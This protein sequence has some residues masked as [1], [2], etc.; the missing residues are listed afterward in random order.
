MS[1]N[2]RIVLAI[3]GSV[4]L[5]TVIV[6]VVLVRRSKPT[7]QALPAPSAPVTQSTFVFKSPVNSSKLL[8]VR[9]SRGAGSSSLT[10]ESPVAVFIYSD[11]CDCDAAKQAFQTFAAS[12]ASYFVFFELNVSVATVA[13]R[14]NELGLEPKTLPA[15]GVFRLGIAS[16]TL[17]TDITE[18]TLQK[19]V[20]K[21]NYKAPAVQQLTMQDFTATGALVNAPQKGLVVVV[22]GQCPM[23]D[24]VSVVIQAFADRVPQCRVYVVDADGAVGKEFL[25]ASNTTV[26][27]YPS[28]L[29]YSENVYVKTPPSAPVL[30]VSGLKA[31]VGLAS[32]DVLFSPPV[33]GAVTADRWNV[34][35]G[36]FASFDPAKPTLIFV[37]DDATL[38]GAVDAFQ[39]FARKYASLATYE[40]L[41]VSKP[42]EFVF[43]AAA[44]FTD[45]APYPVVVKF[46]VGGL[47]SRQTTR[48]FSETALAKMLAYDFTGSVKSVPADF[49]IAGTNTAST[50][51]TSAGPAVVFV[52]SDAC[53]CDAK[54]RVYQQVAD[55]GATNLFFANGSDPATA[56]FFADSKIDRGIVAVHK[57]LQPT[58]AY[59][60][61][62][63]T[64]T[65]DATAV[66]AYVSA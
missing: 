11:A 32:V 51:Y 41:S 19:L 33:A 23:C 35:A 62:P 14:L 20:L 34:A 40:T 66:A 38:T 10:I 59:S 25:S 42:D 16:S 3:L 43:L 31:F 27:T 5:V 46:D 60:P 37:Y 52:F 4:A 44:N 49:L 30:T 26:S 1:T 18:A 2:E 45:P 8:P 55:D 13:A 47:S 24:A 64:T 53:A 9:A 39:K 29:A 61:D 57:W 56:A 36:R 63:I 54:K 65:F 50:T 28:L 17:V 7:P 58:G 12:N 21:A 48:D 15:V 22:T 6:Y